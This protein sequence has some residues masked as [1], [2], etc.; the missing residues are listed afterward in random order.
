MKVFSHYEKV[1]TFVHIAR[2][3]FF[4]ILQKTGGIVHPEPNF[5]GTEP[6]SPLKTKLKYIHTHLSPIS[7]QHRFLK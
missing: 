4:S 5:C 6:F 3:V 1:K 2:N 7:K